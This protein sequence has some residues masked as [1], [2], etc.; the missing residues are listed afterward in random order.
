VDATL[1]ASAH[2]LGA[3]GK[4]IYFGAGR[5]DAEM[6]ME[7]TATAPI[8]AADTTPPSVSIASP[9]G[10]TVSGTV[11]VAVSAKDN[12]GVARVE[13]RINGNTV[14][15]TT[16]APFSMAWNSTAI[17]D[18][19]DTLTAVAYDA[20]GNAAV[21]A[22]VSVNV[23][24]AAPAKVADTTAPTLAIT[25][26]VDGSRVS[27]MV[28]IATSATDNS[29]SAGITQ[30]LSIDGVVRSSVIGTSLRYKWNA[31]NVAAGL[32]TISV[33]ARD[34]AGNTVIRKVTVTR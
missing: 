34:A 31:K 19:F 7:M 17:A 26:P 22:G 32:H 10:G 4:D 1:L 27:G 5:V 30:V 16:T 6:A 21:S 24:N 8:A 25:N 9:T 15:S 20:A 11:T 14:A 18:G 29:G 12:V 13:L 2:D 28:S 23:A 33:T 3:V